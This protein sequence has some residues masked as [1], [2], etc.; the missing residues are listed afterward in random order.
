MPVKRSPSDS[1]PIPETIMV[2]LHLPD[3]DYQ[4]DALLPSQMPISDIKIGLLRLLRA[5]EPKRFSRLG[6]ISISYC[7]KQLP[8]DVTLASQEIWDGS[9]LILGKT[10]VTSSFAKFE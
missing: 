5:C 9:I 7:G 1:H 8:D 2:E 3:M 10:S 4:R 6:G